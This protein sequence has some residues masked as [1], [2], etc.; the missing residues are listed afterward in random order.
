MHVL[1]LKFQPVISIFEYP[2]FNTPTG[3]PPFSMGP[4]SLIVD[5]EGVSTDLEDMSVILSYHQLQYRPPE[6]PNSDNVEF[7]QKKSKEGTYDTRN[8][9]IT[10][11]RICFGAS[12]LS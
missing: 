3:L 6:G 2:R 1:K 9:F 8:T 7:L 12:D 10:I 11:L 4:L 5:L